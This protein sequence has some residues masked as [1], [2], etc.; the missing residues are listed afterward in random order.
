M[1]DVLEDAGWKKGE[2][3]PDGSPDGSWV[4]NSD[5]YTSPDGK[6]VMSYYSYYGATSRDN[7]YG[8]TF[9]LAESP[10]NESD[11]WVE[12]DDGVDDGIN[13][14]FADLRDAFDKIDDRGFQWSSGKWRIRPDELDYDWKIYYDGE[15]WIGTV[16]Y[17]TREYDV[18]NTKVVKKHEIK[19]FLHALN[20]DGFKPMDTMSEST[21][22]R[23]R[24]PTS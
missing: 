8:F 12:N 5:S 11:D 18:W 24:C 7:S 10:M 23:G 13:P 1:R 15:G 20:A 3:K 22:R 6:L 16:N 14:K 19:D 17:K 2:W 9:K 4:S 21:I